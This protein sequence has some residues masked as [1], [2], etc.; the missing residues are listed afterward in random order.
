[1][2]KRF[3]VLAGLLFS[4]FFSSGCNNELNL[5]NKPPIL[6]FKSDLNIKSNERDLSA[7]IIR[8]ADNSVSINVTAPENLDG[9]KIERNNSKSSI[10]KDGLSFKTDEI[11]LPKSSVLKEI[12][13]IL[14][15]IANNLEEKPFY[16]GRAEINFMGKINNEKFELKANKN[17]GFIEKIKIGENT[18]INFFSQ[19]KL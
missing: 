7:N 4:I 2:Q 19:E 10:S 14:D 17:T 13:D 5:G 6:E 9:L 11:L 15:Y 1:M 18:Y 3:I 16:S 12:I 8:K